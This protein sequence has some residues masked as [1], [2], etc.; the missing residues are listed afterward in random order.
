MS[1]TPPAAY[2]S[3]DGNPTDYFGANNGSNG[4][5]TSYAVGKIGQSVVFDGTT[6]S[7]VYVNDSSVFNLSSN[8]F[9]FECWIKRNVSGTREA[10]I[11]QLDSSGT[12]PSLGFN[13]EIFSDNEIRFV[14]YAGT[15]LALNSGL[16]ISDTNWHHIVVT[17]IGFDCFFYLDNVPG[18]TGLINYTLNDSSNMPA[19]GQVGELALFNLNGM[20][21]EFR[22]WN[23][24]GLTP[25]D[26]SFLYNSG[27]GRPYPFEPNSSNFLIMF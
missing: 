26:V 8:D 11:C 1:L 16:Y 20:L 2:W 3:F 25:S 6:N 24:Y 17:R 7:A 10:I 27:A 19:F 21:D 9:A 5:S 15:I 22:L 4:I 14:F 23:G 13:F 18:I 12:G